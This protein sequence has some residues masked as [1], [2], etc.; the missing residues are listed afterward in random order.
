MGRRRKDNLIDTLTPPEREVP[1]SMAEGLS[2]SAIAARLF[3][4]ERAVEKR[5]TGIFGKLHLGADADA[6]RRV[7]AVLAFLED[8]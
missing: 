1:E 2:N 7:L 6:P 4:T 5:I 3:V 8:E